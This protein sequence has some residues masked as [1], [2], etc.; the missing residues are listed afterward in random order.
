MS[1]DQHITRSRP[2]SILHLVE[3]PSEAEAVVTVLEGADFDYEMSQIS[4]RPAFV[5]ALDTA[6]PDIVL[7]ELSLSSWS[8][9]DALEWTRKRH[10]SPIF[11]LLSQSL[12]AELSAEATRLGLSAWLRHD[13]ISML[14]EV[15]GRVLEAQREGTQNKDLLGEVQHIFAHAL[16][17]IWD[18]VVVTDC[19]GNIHYVNR[20][21]EQRTGY[22][23]EEVKGRNPRFLKGGTQRAAFYE[24]LWATLMAGRVWRGEFTNRRKNGELYPEESTITPVYSADGRLEAF[25]AVKRDVS[26]RQTLEED[27]RLAHKL[28][29][30][31]R[32]AGGI[33]HNFNNLM[34][35]AQVSADLV[36]LN[37]PLSPENEREVENIREVLKKASTL[38]KHL[39][40]MS[41]HQFYRWEH[42]SLCSFVEAQ[43]E[44]LREF[45]PENIELLFVPNCGEGFDL[46]VDQEHLGQALVNIILNARDAMPE[47]GKIHLRCK[48]VSAGEDQRGTRLSSE[49][50]YVV[51]EI[52]D[53]GPGMDPRT[54]SKAFDPFFTTREDRGQIGLG[55]SVVHGIVQQ[56]GG[57]LEVDSALG[58]GT[59]FS[60]FLPG[61]KPEIKDPL[62]GDERLA[63]GNPARTASRRDHEKQDDETAAEGCLVLVIEDEAPLRVGML[64]ILKN[65]QLEG[66]AANDAEAALQMIEEG[67]RPQL[68]ISDV[69]LPGMHGPELLRV[70]RKDSI[71]IPFLFCSGYSKEDLEDELRGVENSGFISKPFQ[72]EE[73]GAAIRKL[74]GVET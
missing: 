65:L 30:L 8:G 36:F 18:M 45:L 61:A 72:A 55:L 2:L 28:E 34:T 49:Q 27:L 26:E 23:L 25:V 67:L 74:L 56:H 22:T 50:E 13:R 10:P 31:G 62:T 32:M 58:T 69:K 51:L 71:E 70:L 59:R 16:T 64:R 29:A 24:D 48:G 47:G 1:S 11:I 40:S 5:E 35:A 17:Q 4:E 46:R 53:E 9:L 37:G 43:L 38:T 52:E 20:A 60:I 44:V 41:S 54:L 33:A 39:L 66:I 57:Y 19:R 42:V 7:S 12:E 6:P 21:F 15:I 68:V 73:L 14:P 63:Q 3:Q